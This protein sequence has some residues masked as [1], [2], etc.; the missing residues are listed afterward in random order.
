MKVFYV[1]GLTHTVFKYIDEVFVFDNLDDFCYFSEIFHMKDDWEVTYN[2]NTKNPTDYIKVLNTDP[3]RKFIDNEDDF[4]DSTDEVD[5][6]YSVHSGEYKISVRDYLTDIDDSM[7]E[8]E[9]T[10]EFDRDSNHKIIFADES[11]KLFYSLES[12]Q[13]FLEKVGLENINTECLKV[14]INPFKVT[15]EEY[16]ETIRILDGDMQIPKEV[17]CVETLN[18]FLNAQ[19][20]FDEISDFVDSQ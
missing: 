3:S 6:Y 15:F 13:S 12:L 11:S 1:L 14:Q 7:N 20:D 10:D 8:M 5:E 2:T 4:F 9:I 18:Q 19:S 16:I 17:S